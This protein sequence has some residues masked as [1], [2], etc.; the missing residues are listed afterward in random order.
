MPQTFTCPACG[1]PLDYPADNATAVRCPYCDSTVLTPQTVKEQASIKQAE[2]ELTTSVNLGGDQIEAITRIV[3][4]HQ[5]GKKIEAIKLYREAFGSGLKEAKEAVEAMARGEPATIISRQV[6]SP[7]LIAAKRR[8]RKTPWGCFIVLL[9]ILSLP[10][11]YF[12]TPLSD[13]LKPLTDNVVVGSIAEVLPIPWPYAS[14]ALTIGDEGIGPGKFTD[15]RHVGVDGQGNIYVAEWQEGSR[16]QKFDSEGTFVSLF[17]PVVTDQIVTG[18]AVDRQGKVYVLQ[19]GEIHIYDGTSGEHLGQL[20][21]QGLDY[22]EAIATT[23]ENELVAIWQDGFDDKI[24]RFASEGNVIN[25]ID[26]PISGQTD[27]SELDFH[28]AIDGLNNIYVLGTFTNAVFKYGSNGK[29]VTRFG[30]RGDEPGQFIL[31]DTIAVDSKGRIYVS[32]GWD[33][34]IF[35]SDGRYLNTFNA[36]RVAF[37]LA[38]N[39]NNELFVASRTHVY[40]YA[41]NE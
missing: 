18:L 20:E 5:A 9:I 36:H 15:A 29:F 33:I 41:L 1:A 3:Q 27:D 8:R 4:L 26:N 7:S 16:I 37:G 35:A 11:I 17:T 31:P 30:S 19:I 34:A 23:A 40:K 28:L 32:E 21:Y 25:T 24:V 6:S 2:P 38:F 39:D 12:F 13:S 22:F 10:L 14:L